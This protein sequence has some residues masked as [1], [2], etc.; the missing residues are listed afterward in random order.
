MNSI[1]DQQHGEPEQMLQ[2]AEL[3]NLILGV[4]KVLVQHGNCYFSRKRLVTG[5]EL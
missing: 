4:G 3:P 1:I 5:E 2:V